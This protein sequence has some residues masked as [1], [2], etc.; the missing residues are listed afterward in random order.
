VP[1]GDW[2]RA[3]DLVEQVDGLSFR[4]GA[5]AYR[6]RRVGV[7]AG[8]RSD[9]EILPAAEAQQILTRAA[10]QPDEG[11]HQFGEAPGR[12]LDELLEAQLPL[13]VVRVRPSAP[14]SGSRAPLVEEPPPPISRT[15]KPVKEGW[16]EI[17]VT[18]ADGTLRDADPYRLELPDGRVL[19]GTVGSNGV[20]SI[21]G[22]DPGSAKLT[23][24][25]LN[26]GAWS[27]ASG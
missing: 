11:A 5:T 24:P 20:V 9:E 18:D 12:L 26:G 25:K 19:E 23:F 14:A 10:S 15:R 27:C 3:R 4:L 7:L 1:V 13:I 21:H 6:V 22:I 8:S 17:E 16:I 2:R